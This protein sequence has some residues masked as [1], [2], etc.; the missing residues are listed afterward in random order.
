M[1]VSLLIQR[2]HHL[3]DILAFVLTRHQD[4]DERV[5]SIEIEAG[6]LLFLVSFVSS[7]QPV[8]DHQIL[9]QVVSWNLDEEEEPIGVGNARKRECGNP[10]PEAIDRICYTKHIFSFLSSL[11]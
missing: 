8:E 5:F 3:I 10:V 1:P 7:H 9:Q 11:I 6:K 4:A 2:L